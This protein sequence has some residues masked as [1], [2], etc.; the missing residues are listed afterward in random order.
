MQDYHLPDG[1]KFGDTT[2]R[3][4]YFK[5]YIRDDG[6]IDYNGNQISM[7]NAHELESKIRTNHRELCDYLPWKNQ[8]EGYGYYVTLSKWV[9]TRIPPELKSP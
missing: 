8:K 4:A 5:H 7:S 6:Y 2:I 1:I 3:K 9:E